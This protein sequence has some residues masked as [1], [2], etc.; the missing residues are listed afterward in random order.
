[1]FVLQFLKNIKVRQVEKRPN[2]AWYD[3]S[4]RQLRTGE[5]NF[6]NVKDFL[7]GEW[8]V[9]LCKDKEQGKII[10]KAVKCPAG[11][12]FSQLEGKSMLFQDSKIDGMLYGLLSLTEL[13]ENNRLRRN[14]VSS[15]DEVPAIIKDNYEIKSYE[16]ATGK[17]APGKHFVTLTKQG[18]EKTLVTLF[19]LQR[20]WGLSDSSPEQ[21]LKEKEQ[22]KHD[23]KV[24]KKEVDTGQDLSCP[25]C[26]KKHR[27]MH[28]E[29]KTAVKHLLRK[30]PSQ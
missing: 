26:G 27:L 17:K 18:D 7:T 15:L 13:G 21:K 4:M 24:A 9:K 1:M 10:V 23:K 28:V 11:I 19:V 16:A 29:T 22:A 14:V 30:P 3:M 5:V 12:R 25:I 20:A 8:L 2:D 6:Y